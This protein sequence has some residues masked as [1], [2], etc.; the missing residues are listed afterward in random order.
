MEII[1]YIVIGI[2]VLFAI[3]ALYLFIDA[4]ITSIKRRGDL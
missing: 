3:I 2:F 4:I 1:T